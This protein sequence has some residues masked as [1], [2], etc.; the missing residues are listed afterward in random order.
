MNKHKKISNVL[1][2]NIFT[3]IFEMVFSSHNPHFKN[4]YEEK[5]YKQYKFINQNQKSCI[6]VL[7]LGLNF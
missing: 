1:L 6:R 3:N 5:Q 2:Q 4:F 7:N